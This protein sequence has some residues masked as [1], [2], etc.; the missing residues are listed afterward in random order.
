[1]LLNLGKEVGYGRKESRE[2]RPSGVRMPGRKGT[3]V[4]QPILRE[5]GQGIFHCLQLRA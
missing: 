3:Q 5:R 4:L 1:M 2:V